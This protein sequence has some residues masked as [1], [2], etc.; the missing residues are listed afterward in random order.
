MTSFVLVLVLD[1][2]PTEAAVPSDA[3]DHD[4]SRRAPRARHGHPY[5]P[6]AEGAAPDAVA[7]SSAQSSA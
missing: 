5:R 4:R 7:S 2:S 6:T 3:G 1:S